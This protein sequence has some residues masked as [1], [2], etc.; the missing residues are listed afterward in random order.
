MVIT[1]TDSLV[2]DLTQAM[3][4][5][6]QVVTPEGTVL[7][8]AATSTSAP[9]DVSTN[10]LLAQLLLNPREVLP[11]AGSKLKWWHMALGGAGALAVGGVVTGIVVTQGEAVEPHQG[12]IVVGPVP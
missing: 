10:V 6:L 9:L 5:L 8:I 2:N 4:E 1:P 12:T 3:P 11:P 7:S